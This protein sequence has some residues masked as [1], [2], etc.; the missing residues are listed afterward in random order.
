MEEGEWA[1]KSSWSLMLM[2]KQVLSAGVRHWSSCKR[3][4]LSSLPILHFP[5]VAKFTSV[6]LQSVFR[7]PEK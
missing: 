7:R 2:Q 4:P 5:C 1:A 6:L 3:S